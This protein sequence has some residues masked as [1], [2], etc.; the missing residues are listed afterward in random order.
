[1]TAGEYRCYNSQRGKLTEKNIS[2]I[3]NVIFKECSSNLASKMIQ[4]KQSKGK[5][6]LC[7][8]W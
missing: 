1:M 8:K 4:L 2:A 7:L 3:Q 5:F 6:S